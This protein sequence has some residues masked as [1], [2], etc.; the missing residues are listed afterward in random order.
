[1]KYMSATSEKDV[2]GWYQQIVTNDA[3][4]LH[5]TSFTSFTTKAK[6]KRANDSDLLYP[7]VQ[8]VLRVP[9]SCG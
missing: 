8:R 6:A 3:E 9:P 5:F 7:S 1:M 2:F 4:D